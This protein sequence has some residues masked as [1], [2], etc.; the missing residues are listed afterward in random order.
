LVVSVPSI[1]GGIVV[2]GSR[3]L[4]PV[5]LATVRSGFAMPVI[6]TVHFIGTI[7]TIETVL[8]IGTVELVIVTGTVGTIMSGKV[9]ASVQSGVIDR[10]GQVGTLGLL[11]VVN[12][13]GSIS[14]GI[15]DQARYV[16]T[17]GTIQAGNVTASISSGV[18]D[19]ARYVGTVDVVGSLR[20]SGTLPVEVRTP[21]TV[22]IRDQIIYSTIVAS[23]SPSTVS[24]TFISPSVDALY[25]PGGV[26]F[27]IAYIAGQNV[28]ATVLIQNSIDNTLF[29]TRAT[30]PIATLSQYDAVFS[31]TRRYM[32]FTAINYSTLSATI[33][34]VISLLPPG[35]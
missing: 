9:T 27:S 31:P 5:D 12:R 29:R 30:V 19:Q 34:A 2:V 20:T 23:L 11:D 10:V 22:V 8:E 3:I 14:A 4:L 35:A 28:T 6:G 16:G 26:G 1:T 32:R 13:L 21:A 18:L 15:I 25:Y 24:G 33:D 7:G 17:L